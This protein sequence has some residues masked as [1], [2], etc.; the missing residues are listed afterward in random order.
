MSISPRNSK[1]GFTLVEL[2]VVIAIIG[3]LVGL[4][5][6]AVQAA[7]EAARRATCQNNIRQIML[8]CTNY[9]SAQMRFPGGASSSLIQADTA[10]SSFLVA[11]LPY[12]DANNTYELIKSGDGG[13]SPNPLADP[14]IITRQPL[15][16]CQSAAQK[17]ESDDIFGTTASH[18]VGISGPAIA[19][20][21]GDG[22]VDF[23]VHFPNPPLSAQGY[24][25]AI[26]CDGVFSPF[27][28][29]RVVLMN[30]AGA[31][32]TQ[33]GST[34]PGTL[35]R[36]FKNNRGVN[37]QDIG[38]GSSNTIAIAEFSGGEVQASDPA[39]SFIPIRG[40]YGYGATTIPALA[41]PAIRGLVNGFYVP[42]VVYQTRGIFIDPSTGGGG[43]NSRQGNL[44][45][46]QNFNH[47]PLNSAHPGGVNVARAD[48]SVSFVDDGISGA[49]LMSLSGVDDGQVV[50]DY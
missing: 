24:G 3:I 37:F 10:S 28:N 38:D 7:R 41:S 33:L 6:P 44:Y 45:A 25:G 30:G 4:L 50:S 48:G 20:P 40:G 34:T 9:Q 5:L 14:G 42:Q 13:L 17:D 22:F 12:M 8:A 19:D 49:N 46:P 27:S 36:G 43:L 39:N 23:R 11:I 2:L 16:I 21:D 26:G 15:F 18:Y 47:A 1:R 35:F 32:S 29:D 31:T